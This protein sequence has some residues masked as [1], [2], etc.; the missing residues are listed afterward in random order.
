MKI[1]RWNKKAKTTAPP[2][3]AVKGEG[4]LGFPLEHEELIQNLTILEERETAVIV[5]QKREGGNIKRGRG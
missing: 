3:R 5:S 1:V 4:E 2:V